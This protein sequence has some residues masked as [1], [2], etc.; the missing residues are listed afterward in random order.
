MIRKVSAFLVAVS[1]WLTAHPVLAQFAEQ[2]TFGGVSGGSANAQTFTINNVLS[3]A[4]IFGVPIKFQAGF[5]NT[6]VLQINVS[7]LGFKSVYRPVPGGANTT[8]GGEVVV[9]QIVTVVWDGVN[10]QMTSAPSLP[11]IPGAIFD[12]AGASGCPVGSLLA[13]GDASSGSLATVLGTT[14]GSA[15][16]LPDLRGRATFGP[17]SGGSNRIT[18][19][20]GNFDG[21]VVG[22]T[23]GQQNQTL[24]QAQLP[25]IVPTFTGSSVNLSSQVVTTNTGQQ[26]RNDVN[27]FQAMNTSNAPATVT[28]TA[29]GTIGSING[30]VTEQAHPVLS[31]A[32]IV[33]KCVKM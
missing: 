3:L 5:A 22:N 6:S 13:N 25:N 21:T 14:W 8:V 26:A 24:T 20:G 29:A 7:G 18:V 11:Y 2:A 12:Y 30:N 1:V 16:T 31:N 33:L 32:A 28:V 4:D 10:F 9:N 27:N 23:G 15:G 19:A 17:D